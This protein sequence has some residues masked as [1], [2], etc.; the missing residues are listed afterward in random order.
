MLLHLLLE[1]SAHCLC[2]TTGEFAAMTLAE[3][4]KALELARDNWEGVILNN[5]STCCM[6][7]SMQLLEHSAEQVSTPQVS[8]LHQQV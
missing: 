8:L 5:I 7:D 1:S 3:R 4:K 6:A 2:R